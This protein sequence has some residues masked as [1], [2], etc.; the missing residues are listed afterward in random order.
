M[1]PLA[2]EKSGISPHEKVHDITKE[3]RKKLT[4]LL[5]GLPMTMKRTGPYTEAVVTKGGVSTKE[6]DSSTMESK[7]KKGLY[8]AGEVIEVDAYTGGYNLQIAWSTGHLAGE[9]AAMEG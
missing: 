7:K 2:I 5:K 4:A 3:Q 6:I 1:I 8:F 9:S